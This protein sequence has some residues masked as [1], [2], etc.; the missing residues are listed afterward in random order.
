MIPCPDNAR[1][2]PVVR[3][4]PAVRKYLLHLSPER[5][6]STLHSSAGNEHLP[7]SAV[8]LAGRRSTHPLPC[9]RQAVAANGR[10]V[11]VVSSAAPPS[12]EVV[13]EPRRSP[14]SPPRFRLS[15]L[16]TLA[17]QLRLC[18]FALPG[19]GSEAAT[20]LSAFPT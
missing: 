3:Q 11:Q 10:P 17:R 6:Y 1:R 14:P 18:C 12:C 9:P 15:G 8:Q 4:M 20:L 13:L 19:L 16:L 7:L 2:L 5:R